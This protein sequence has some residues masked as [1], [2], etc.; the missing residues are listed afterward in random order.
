MFIGEIIYSKDIKMKL[1]ILKETRFSAI[2]CYPTYAKPHII[3]QY[4]I[5]LCNGWDQAT[6]AQSHDAFGV[7]YALE[8][9][10]TLNLELFFLHRISLFTP[11]RFPEA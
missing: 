6:R 5:C 11:F 3:C 2:R 7:C 4:L 9:L 10:S 1:L 8:M